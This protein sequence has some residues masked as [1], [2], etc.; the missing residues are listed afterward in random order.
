MKIAIDVIFILFLLVMTVVGYRKGF[1]D[2]A[3]WLMDIVIIVFLGMNFE[4]KLAQQLGDAG[5][6]AAIE[7]ALSGA[8]GGDTLFG[9][10]VADIAQIAVSV[11]VWAG[12]A[13]VVAIVMAIVKAILK[14]LRKFLSFR[15]IDGVLGAMYGMVITLVVL[16]VIGAVAGTFTDFA[17]VS[18]AYDLCGQTHLFRYIFGANPFQETINAHFPLGSWIYGALQS[19]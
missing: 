10:P 13:I 9:K 17:P 19:K 3:W 14:S 8:A 4:P 16:L 11:I 7:G 12:L 5:L 2:R 18:S 15:V 1:L 6:T